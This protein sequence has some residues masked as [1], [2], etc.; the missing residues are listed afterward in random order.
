MDASSPVADA[1]LAYKYPTS[2]GKVGPPQRLLLVRVGPG[3]GQGVPS[4]TLSHSRI[5]WFA[6][7]L[8]HGDVH[9]AAFMIWSGR[10]T[11]PIA[12]RLNPFN[13]LYELKDSLQIRQYSPK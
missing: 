5:G 1:R 10:L 4:P 3:R 7:L 13:F 6:H 8:R 11:T 2:E 12:L 9:H